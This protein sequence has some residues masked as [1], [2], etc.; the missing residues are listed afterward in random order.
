MEYKLVN[1]IKFIMC[2]LMVMLF[3]YKSWDDPGESIEIIFFS[4]S[5]PILITYFVGFFTGL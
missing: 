2:M 4:V 5:I 3:F 1:I